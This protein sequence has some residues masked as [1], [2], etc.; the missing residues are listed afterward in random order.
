MYL[1]ARGHFASMLTYVQQRAKILDMM[2]SGRDD[3]VQSSSGTLIGYITGPQAGQP[4][5][6]RVVEPP[7]NT[8][9]SQRGNLYVIVELF[10]NSPEH[11]ALANRMLG[12]LQRAYYTAKGSQAEV[13]A[14]GIDA[15]HK[16]LQDYN[17]E[18][19][20]GPVAAGLLCA[21]LLKSRLLIATSGSAFALVRAGQHVH[22]FPSEVEEN[23]AIDAV[24][25]RIEVFRQ[26]VAPDDVVF[27]GGGSWLHN[28]PL[29]T[30]AGI[31]AYTTEDT[32]ADAADELYDRS[33]A[34]QF[35]GL[36]IV[37]GGDVPPDPPGG[38]GGDDPPS[39]GAHGGPQEGHGSRAGG[40]GLLRSRRP[41]AG[42]GLPT[43]LG[44]VPAGHPSSRAPAT[45]QVAAHVAEA[46]A[47]AIGART[48]SALPGPEPPPGEPDAEVD[49]GWAS[50][51]EPPSF[52]AESPA[53]AHEA[54]ETGATS[55][56][57]AGLAESGEPS[58]VG[59]SLASGSRQFSFGLGRTWSALRGLF[60]RMLPDAGGARKRSEYDLEP[61][62]SPDFAAEFVEGEQAGAR[63][64]R[65]TAYVAGGATDIGHDVPEVADWPGAFVP[66]AFDDDEP[67]ARAVVGQAEALDG[68]WDGAQADDL[69]Q[70][71]AAEP[72]VARHVEAPPPLP[73]FEPF[74]PPEP[75]RGARARL[76]I[77][78]AV[79]IVVLAPAVVGGFYLSEAP[80][81]RL[82]A[83]ELTSGAASLL[84]SARAALDVG[85]SGVGRSDLTEAQDLLNQAVELDDWTDRRR[86]LAA[87][88]TLELDEVAQRLPLYGLTTPILTFEG[89]AS[90]T[91]IVVVNDEIYILDPGRAA[92]YRYRFDPAAGQVLAPEG[93]V[94][95]RQGDTVGDVVVGSLH[96]LAWLPLTAGREDK[97]SLL[98]LDRQNNVFRFDQRVEGVTRLV[99]GDQETWGSI[100]QIETYAGRVYV[101][102]EV[103]G[104][105]YRYEAGLYELPGER[106][107][108]PET[109]T[110]FTGLRDMEIDGDIWFLYENGMV[111]RYRDR[112]QVSFTLESGL[113][114]TDNPSDFYVAREG[115]AFI[116][117][118]DT[119]Q[120]RILV[121]DKEGRY[122]YQ[123][124]APEGEALRGVSG[125][126]I[127]EIAGRMF[128]LTQDALYLHPLVE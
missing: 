17:R 69:A 11:E 116:Y 123:L 6:V 13:M 48:A 12:V 26:D 8:R 108:A 42:G 115:Q 25:E 95:L 75:A 103:N 5:G 81:R 67:E 43:A 40:G 2:P 79:M 14:T 124:V 35:P 91:R 19:E 87:D 9:Q 1:A 73:D 127:D 105:I 122:Q 99:F 18:H 51:A 121:Y 96:D 114:F 111:L 126:E 125:L 33:G 107:F 29:R 4:P 112:Q 47:A 53:L 78:L 66:G 56:A 93:Q 41:R 24:P 113:G 82:E 36:I 37:L 15:A 60:T 54:I 38:P 85:D 3:S 119:Q 50:A 7:P 88:I 61:E 118:V 68:A 92:V 98:V 32:C 109:L 102:D 21:A 110:S 97:P 22:M 89:E 20:D 63:T 57:E 16:L 52:A 27:L 58:G 101:A 23:G 72:D 106:W 80:S 62:A 83:E 10:G 86:A 34:S 74:T 46:D 59:A 100:G 70:I 94:V 28:V 128:I 44:A 49:T 71:E 104:Q 90:P 65:Q 117:V 31:V 77:L 120:A 76:F 45:T 64:R 84:I 39:G 55:I 30:L